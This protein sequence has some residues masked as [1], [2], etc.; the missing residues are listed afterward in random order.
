MERGAHAQVATRTRTG[1]DAAGGGVHQT[2][3]S[4][5]G[6]QDPHEGHKAAEEPVRPR[7]PMCGDT[8]R[9]SAS[10]SAPLRTGRRRTPTGPRPRP[11]K[12]GGLWEDSTVSVD[13]GGRQRCEVR[14]TTKT[15]WGRGDPEPERGVSPT[16]SAPSRGRRASADLPAPETL[17][18]SCPQSNQ[19]LKMKNVGFE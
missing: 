18:S 3:Q 8:G 1:G 9:T 15:L 2:P 14:V 16:P 13:L 10:A 17:L 11:S 6:Q 12:L 19:A 7:S 5:A 4:R